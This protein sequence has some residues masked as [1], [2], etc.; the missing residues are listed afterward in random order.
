MTI[1]T[2]VL[3]LLSATMLSWSAE[4]VHG[5]LVIPKFSNLDTKP[6]DGPPRA[7]GL[8]RAALLSLGTGRL[9]E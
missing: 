2:I 3:V 8:D 4:V 1:V 7:A 5:E 6:T 9:T